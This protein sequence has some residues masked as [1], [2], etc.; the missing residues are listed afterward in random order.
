MATGFSSSPSPVKGLQAKPDESPETKTWTEHRHRVIVAQPQKPGQ[1]TGK[2]T[3][4]P[5]KK[6]LASRPQHPSMDKTLVAL[7]DRNKLKEKERKKIEREL[8]KQRLMAMTGKDPKFDRNFR[9]K[10]DT[11][12]GSQSPRQDAEQGTER[13]ESNRPVTSPVNDKKQ[14][15]QKIVLHKKRALT[16]HR[17]SPTPS[18]DEK[19]VPESTTREK[20]SESDL[21][22]VQYDTQDTFDDWI[23]QASYRKKNELFESERFRLKDG[24]P[25]VTDDAL[26][27]TDL[28]R[29]RALT[30]RDEI[31][32]D[33]PPSESQREIEAL[34]Q[35]SKRKTDDEDITWVG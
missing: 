11:E 27:H 30:E 1:A 17:S 18:A 12:Y 34:S 2:E 25:A 20:E 4:I 19:D 14:E 26:L 8:Q 21:E 3:T 9:K 35:K 23:R 22:S 16:D 29:T 33:I 32:K 24:S 10:P 7:D 15:M 5:V 6:I 13:D 31:I 28:K